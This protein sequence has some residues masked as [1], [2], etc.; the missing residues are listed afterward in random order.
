MDF[1]TPK[2]SINSCS[3]RFFFKVVIFLDKNMSYINGHISRIAPGK[4]I[5]PRYLHNYQDDNS[6]NGSRPLPPPNELVEE[7]KSNADEIYL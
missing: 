5:V 2:I 7:L 4:N 1:K 6:R 3:F